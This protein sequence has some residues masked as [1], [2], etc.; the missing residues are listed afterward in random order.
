VAAA[1][2][3]PLFHPGRSLPKNNIHHESFQP[4]IKMNQCF[5]SLALMSLNYGIGTNKVLAGFDRTM[6]NCHMNLTS[7]ALT[8]ESP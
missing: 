2:R 1:A 3:P 5:V 4:E 6:D 7:Q 8:A